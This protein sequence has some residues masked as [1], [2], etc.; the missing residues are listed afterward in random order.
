VAVSDKTFSVKFPRDRSIF[1][2]AQTENREPDG[3]GRQHRECEAF[4]RA[5]VFPHDEKKSEIEQRHRNYRNLKSDSEAV[6]EFTPWN[7]NAA[8]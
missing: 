7:Y 6:S 8:V 1:Q 3:V 4:R 5:K 2:V